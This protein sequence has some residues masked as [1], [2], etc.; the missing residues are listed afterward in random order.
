MR[1]ATKDGGRSPFV[2]KQYLNLASSRSIPTP[3]NQTT[4]PFM[5]SYTM[6]YELYSAI[7]YGIPPS[8]RRSTSLNPSLKYKRWALLQAKMRIRIPIFAAFLMPLSTS[9]M[10]SPCLCFPGELQDNPVLLFQISDF[11]C[12]QGGNIPIYGFQPT[13]ACE[14]LRPG[15]PLSWCP[16]P[17]AP[18]MPYCS[19]LKTPSSS[20]YSRLESAPLSTPS[21]APR[22]VS[23]AH[24]LLLHHSHQRL[25]G[26]AGSRGCGGGCVAGASRPSRS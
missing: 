10:R 4:A 26:D 24:T 8:T 2:N 9:A 22:G 7:P 16:D 1:H 3:S 6:K 13:T 21:L 14:Y 15:H 23:T 18:T 11:F 19:S 20:P 5:T 25:A 17:R 12:S